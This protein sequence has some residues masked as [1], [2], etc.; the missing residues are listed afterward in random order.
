MVVLGN[1]HKG[2]KDKRPFDL[3]FVSCR[4]LGT[5]NVHSE[6]GVPKLDL[7]LD[8]RPVVFVRSLVGSWLQ[9]LAPALGPCDFLLRQFLVRMLNTTSS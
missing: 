8:A 1:E 6:V 7:S 5:I 9:R 3:D 4:A 2:P